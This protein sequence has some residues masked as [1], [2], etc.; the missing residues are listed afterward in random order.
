MDHF[1]TLPPELRCMIADQ[2]DNESLV[3][4]SLV[5]TA[6]RHPS[7]HA[8]YRVIHK[9]V[10]RPEDM[11]TIGGPDEP[12]RY[13]T[14]WIQLLLRTMFECPDLSGYVQQIHWKAHTDWIPVPHFGESGRRVITSRKRITD[15][16]F[17]QLG[18]KFKKRKEEK[19]FIDRSDIWE[20]TWEAALMEGNTDAML[21]L[22]L[23]HFDCLISL[24]LAPDLFYYSHFLGPIL[25]CMTTL[26]PNYNHF[27][28]L[29]H[30]ALCERGSVH[31]AGELGITCK[32]DI[33]IPHARD[34]R[35]LE[36]TIH[37][38]QMRVM[39]ND[40]FNIYPCLTNLRLRFCDLS[41]SSIGDILDHTPALKVFHCGLLRKYPSTAPT[42]HPQS[43][44]P[45]MLDFSTL[46]TDLVKVADT[47]EELTVDLAWTSLEF[48]AYEGGP[49]WF[50]GI[51]VHSLTHLNRLSYLEIPAEILMGLRPWGCTTLNDI[52]PSKL[53]S[54]MLIESLHYPFAEFD[55]ETHGLAHILSQ[56]IAY[57]KDQPR[58]LWNVTL[59][60]KVKGEFFISF[61][62][63]GEKIRQYVDGLKQIKELA[64]L[65]VS[66]P[67]VVVDIFFTSSQSHNEVVLWRV[68]FE[69][70]SESEYGNLVSWDSS[71]EA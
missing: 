10:Q 55:M 49:K 36:L 59:K 63:F 19:H 47:L 7:Q 18:L 60:C 21:P 56:L 66:L 42:S 35:T 41:I 1:S 20:K 39:Q 23:A 70:E 17:T 22:V 61:A 11:R 50:P 53:E 13:K 16:N 65:I 4:L 6:F 9:E 43:T 30:L 5:S 54:L 51:P 3:S 67:D 28:R 14:S 26:A 64:E 27:P 24:D 40:L 12:N 2:C 44:S 62:T 8:L 57:F 46:A 34:I 71:Y 29:Q 69:R 32:G 52:L 58:S 25:A 38:T 37:D 33:T 68:D 31:D 15:P 48:F 45:S